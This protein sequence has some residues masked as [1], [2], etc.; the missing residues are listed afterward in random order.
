MVGR[1]C[2]VLMASLY[3]VS[4]V[5]GGFVLTSRRRLRALV[6]S[7]EKR[8]YIT[9]FQSW[10]SFAWQSDFEW[11]TMDFETEFGLFTTF[12]CKIARQVQCS[13]SMIL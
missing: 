12:L 13:E 2:A 1:F 10:S 8:N 3:L 9:A 5:V 11:W 7:E 4:G 6:L